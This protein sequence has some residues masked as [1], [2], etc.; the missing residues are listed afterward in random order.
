MFVAVAVRW[1]VAAVRRD[2]DRDDAEEDYKATG[3]DQSDFRLA[4][5]LLIVC[6]RFRSFAARDVH[7][8]LNGRTIA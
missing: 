4:N 8:R 6:F 7:R 3:E 1:E 5:L 2:I